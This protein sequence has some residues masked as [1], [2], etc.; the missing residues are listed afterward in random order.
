MTTKVVNV[1]AG[2][3]YDVYI[4]RGG[5]SDLG[6]PFKIGVHG[7]REQVV[8]TYRVYFYRRIRSDPRFKTNILKLKGKTLG[9]FCKPLDCHGDIIAEYLNNESG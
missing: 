6:N 7:N 1:N 2:V 5:N 8:A 4:G 3:Y 9:C